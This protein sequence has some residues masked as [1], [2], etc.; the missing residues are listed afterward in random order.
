MSYFSLKRNVRVN[1]AERKIA[2]QVQLWTIIGPFITLLTICLI[3][4]KAPANDLLLPYVALLGIPICWLWKKRGLVVSLGLLIGLLVFQFRSIPQEEVLWQLGLSLAIATTFFIIALSFEEVSEIVNNIQ[5]QIQVYLEQANKAEINFKILNEESEKILK[6]REQ[7]ISKIS[8]LEESV[9]NGKQEINTL[10]AFIAKVD[11]ELLSLHAKYKIAVEDVFQKENTVQ[12]LQ[13]RL[14]DFEEMSDKVN[15]QKNRIID[16]ELQISLIKA[17]VEK[18]DSKAQTFQQELQ[19]A[20]RVNEI[21][22]EA[23]A[24]AQEEQN[25]QQLVFQ[26]LNEEIE[27]LSREKNL[28]E[29]VLV[30]LQTEVE[31]LRANEKEKN[32]KAVSDEIALEGQEISHQ[33]EVESQALRIVEGKYNQLREQ[34]A[35]KSHVLDSSRRE[36]FH[37]QEKLLSFQKNVEEERL[38]DSDELGIHFAKQVGQFEKELTLQNFHYQKEIESLEQIITKLI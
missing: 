5:K 20:K 33:C 17:E 10:T 22:E 14:K 23:S 27:T 25:I 28:L 6:E 32:D 30:R 29:S 34:F 2:S 24:K 18:I 8:F 21:N 3:I 7:L 16:L 13:A 11:G 37:V 12:I 1:T 4:I 31:I 26:E 36:L 9:E 38:H 35:E 15:W 19:A